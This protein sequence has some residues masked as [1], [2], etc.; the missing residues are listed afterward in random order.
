MA[1]P[2]EVA[3]MLANGAEYVMRGENYSDIDWLNNKP[4]FTKTQFEAG[5]AQYDAWK[6]EQ[7]ATQTAAKKAVLDR[8][9]I[10]ADEAKL[11]LS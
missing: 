5:F 1:K 8:L 7:N 6:A 9:G 4:A 10:T 11:L 3:N 2:N